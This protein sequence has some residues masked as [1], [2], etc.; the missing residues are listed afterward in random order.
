M[1]NDKSKL[2]KKSRGKKQYE[3]IEVLTRI[4]E[5]C[6]TPKTPPLPCDPASFDNSTCK[7]PSEVLQPEAII[8]FRRP[9]PIL[10]LYFSAP[11]GGEVAPSVYNNGCFSLNT[12]SFSSVLALDLEFSQ[13]WWFQSLF[14]SALATTISLSPGEQLRISIETSQRKYFERTSLDEVEENDSSESQIV[15]RDVINITRSSARIKN[16]NVSGGGSIS[17]PIKKAELGLNLSGSISESLEKN[18]SSST[19]KVRDSTQKSSEALRSLQRVEV[20][21]TIET[22]EVNGRSRL[23]R[24][25]YRDRSLDLKVYALAKKFCVEFSLEKIRPSLIFEINDMPFTRKFVQSNA[26]FLEKYLQDSRLLFE[27][28]EA[29]ESLVDFEN[30]TAFEDIEKISKIALHYL[31]EEPNIFNVKELAGFD[32]NDP[33]SSFDANLPGNGLNDATNNK[34]G[35]IFTTLNFYYAIY[36][37]E[38]PLDNKLYLTLALSLES[39]LRPLWFGVEET[40]KSNNVLDSSDFTETFRRLGGF[41]TLV[42]GSVRPLLHPAEEDRDTLERARHAEFVIDRVISH[43][44]CHRLFY[45]GKYLEY[46]SKLADGVTFSRMIE[47]LM[48]DIDEPNELKN[49]WEEIFSTEDAFISGNQI[50]IPGYCAYDEATTRKFLKEYEGTRNIRFG[51]LSKTHV[52]SP[53]DGTHIEPVCGDCILSEIPPL[54]ESAPIKVSILHNQDFL[55]SDIDSTD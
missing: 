12:V 42:G 46:I 35:L 52:Y 47:E 53:T 8:N 50:I 41:L 13:K 14:R 37:K 1:I 44:K 15:D 6:R 21:E 24:N 49:N 36:K 27:L 3:L 4:Q 34:L 20:K 45:I 22:S 2:Y 16:W 9:V 54:E 29:L 23:L 25:P 28:H 26:S 11:E 17:I 7:G 51:L 32:A 39:A 18:S 30:R 55:F 19:E 10:P 31:F 48:E 40:E 5:T 33:A 38:T 43:L